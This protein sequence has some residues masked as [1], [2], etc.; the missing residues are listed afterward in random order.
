[1]NEL[2]AGW[3]PLPERAQSTTTTLDIQQECCLY[4]GSTVADF[5]LETVHRIDTKASLECLHTLGT[6]VL[7][8]AIAAQGD[9]IWVVRG[10]EL[11]WGERWALERLR[12][13]GENVS[14]LF[15]WG[16]DLVF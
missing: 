13:S 12:R 15:Q 7:E 5:F 1:M 10:L 11:G 4:A 2:R 14:P 3:L 8:R 6:H 9:C 16:C